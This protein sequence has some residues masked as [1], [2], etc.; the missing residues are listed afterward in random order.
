MRKLWIQRLNAGTR[1]YGM[2][3]SKFIENLKHTNIVMNRKV[4]SNLAIT[5]PL[6]FKSIVELVKQSLPK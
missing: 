2:P 3:Y 4:L 6:S 5:E 1:M